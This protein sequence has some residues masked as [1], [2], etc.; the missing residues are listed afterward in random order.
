MVLD[1]QSLGKKN[2]VNGTPVS[3]QSAPETIA[4]YNYT[5]PVMVDQ[6]ALATG[7]GEQPPVIT[8]TLLGG[9]KVILAGTNGFAGDTCYVLSTTNLATPTGSWTYEATNTFT[10]NAFTFTNTLTPGLA[11]KFYL[12]KI[13]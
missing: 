4:F 8:S 11:Q 1:H 7:L 10:G 2:W 5:A 9:G 12:L 6:V 13:Q 3:G